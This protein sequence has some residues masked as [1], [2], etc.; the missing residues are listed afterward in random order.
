MRGPWQ[1]APG[2]SQRSGALHVHIQDSRFPFQ[3]SL[4]QICS[5]QLSW[6]VLLVYHVR[7]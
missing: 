6:Q 1:R 3:F 2:C 7:P 4:L 5:C